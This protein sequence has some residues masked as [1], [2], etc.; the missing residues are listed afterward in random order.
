M[1]FETEYVKDYEFQ[2][3]SVGMFLNSLQDDASVF[4]IALNKQS[5]KENGYDLRMDIKS[6]I[7]H[8]VGHGL[9]QYLNE[10][11]DLDELDEEIVV[12]E[13]ARDYCDNLLSQNELYHILTHQGDID[14]TESKLNIENK[15]KRYT[16][17]STC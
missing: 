9:F 2:N 10:M 17:R 16:T 3:D 8:E 13:F 7:A 1:V 15:I 12:E 5:I 6:T 4:P 14:I 11:L